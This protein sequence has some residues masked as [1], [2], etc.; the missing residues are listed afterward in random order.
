[1]ILNTHYLHIHMNDVKEPNSEVNVG[2][3]VEHINANFCEHF[4]TTNNDVKFTTTDLEEKILFFNMQMK[5]YLHQHHV[6][7]K[8]K[9]SCKV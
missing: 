1:M 2:E 3:D 7:N 6:M 4:S 5:L 8:N 9:Y